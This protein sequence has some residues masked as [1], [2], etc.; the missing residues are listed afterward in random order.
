MEKIIN[1]CD[2]LLKIFSYI[3]PDEQKELMKVCTQFEYAIFHGIW[4]LHCKNFS[5]SEIKKN[6]FFLQYCPENNSETRKERRQKFQLMDR[7]LHNFARHIRTLTLKGICCLSDM[8][9]INYQ[10]LTE[11]T[12]SHTVVQEYHIQQLAES[13]LN[14]QS[15]T[16]IK[17]TTPIIERNIRANVFGKIKAL[18][19][20][21]INDKEFTTW[22]YYDVQQLFYISHLK[23]LIID[24][25]I[26]TCEYDSKQSNNYSFGRVNSYNIENLT[27]GDLTDAQLSDI[28]FTVD[29]LSC[30]NLTKLTLI[31]NSFPVLSINDYDLMRINYTCP[32]LCELSFTGCYLKFQEFPYMNN[33]IHLTFRECKN[34]GTEKLY[35]IF[36]KV[37]LKS[38]SIVSVRERVRVRVKINYYC[39]SDTL[40][41]L[42]ITEGLDLNTVRTFFKLQHRFENVSKISLAMGASGFEGSTKLC[43][44]HNFPYLQELIMDSFYISSEDI[45][46]LEHLKVLKFGLFHN[47]SW[48]YLG[49][50]FKHPTL[51]HITITPFNCRIFKERYARFPISYKGLTTKLEYLKLPSVVY[52]SALNFWPPF[53]RMN[54]LLKLEIFNVK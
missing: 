1:N 4:R 19:K 45:L 53:R 15:L 3:H 25:H 43:F 48:S 28:C 54:N 5:I 31:S 11:L 40:E 16:L 46:H 10:H 51:T 26:N 27:I 41:T 35:K 44:S 52:G 30:K 20:L 47:M 18:N 6:A 8:I 13:C 9:S 32:K 7:I 17:F 2:L 22:N 33:L 12:L 34:I 21:E 49:I 37:T 24:I 39:I 36:R 42:T 50:L 38:L 14:L 23:T 29:L